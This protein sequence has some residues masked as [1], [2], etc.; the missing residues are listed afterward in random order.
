M[1]SNS[2]LN[3]LSSNIQDKVEKV[4]RNTVTNSNLDSIPDCTIPGYN[5]PTLITPQESKPAREQIIELYNILFDPAVA[6]P[7]K[8]SL[9]TQG[10]LTIEK[11]NE[12]RKEEMK[13]ILF[14]ENVELSA[15]DKAAIDLTVKETVKYLIENLA[16]H[17]GV[18]VVEDPF[19][20][21]TYSTT[22]FMRPII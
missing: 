19:I 20:S 13:T 7:V 9:A 11:I 3:N 2:G 1:I 16:Q 15:M 22:V 18:T 4:L 5:R 6:D 14:A 12:T 10:D 8:Q 17:I 21:G